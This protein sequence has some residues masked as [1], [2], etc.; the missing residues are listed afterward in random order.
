[1]LISS[2]HVNF[3]GTDGHVHELYARPRAQLGGQRSPGTRVAI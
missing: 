2:V 1:M 3:I